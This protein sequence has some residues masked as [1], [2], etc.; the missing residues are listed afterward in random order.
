VFDELFVFVIQQYF[1]GGYLRS[2]RNH[3][4]SFVKTLADSFSFA[5]GNDGFEE[6]WRSS[7]CSNV[8]SIASRE[9][10]QDNDN[11][12]YEGALRNHV[13]GNEVPS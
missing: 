6:T 2:E 8:F 12:A 5:I 9:A 4:I 1:A 7:E 3:A 11:G 10:W 13:V